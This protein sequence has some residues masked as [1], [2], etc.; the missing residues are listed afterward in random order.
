MELFFCDLALKFQVIPLVIQ[1][2]LPKLYEYHG[3]IVFIFL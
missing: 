1:L 2:V 3:Y